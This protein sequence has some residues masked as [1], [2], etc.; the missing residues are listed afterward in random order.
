MI[1]K[2]FLEGIRITKELIHDIVFM[3]ENRTKPTYF[4]RTSNCKMD[5]TNIIHFQLNF[6]KKTLQLELDAFFKNIKG[7]EK[8][9]TKQGYSEARQKISPAAFIKMAD[10]IISWYY[11]DDSFKKFKGY[12]LCAIDAS[13]LEL[14]NSK[15]L[16]EAYGYGEGKTVKLARAKASAIYDIENDMALTSK[17]ARYTTGER[18]IAIELIEKLKQL[19]LKNDLILFD[20]GYP[21]KAFISYLEDSG[22]KY[23]IR[24]S[25]EKIKQ[26]REAVEP[27]QIIE[28]R[29]GKKTVKTRVVRFMLDSDVEEVLLTNLFDPSL[30]TQGF[31]ELYFK[32]WGIEVKYDEIKN[33]LQ[34]ENFT[35]DTVIAVEQDF[36]ASIY[37]S[38]MAALAKNEANERV[39]LRNQGKNLKYDYRVNV[40]ILIGKLK[41]SMVLMLLEDNPDKR[42]E[43]FQR[44][45]DE[46]SKNV[47]PT[48]PGRAFNRRKSLNANKH[49]ANQKRSL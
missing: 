35:G 41:D 26:V 36:Y 16:R 8:T 48:R 19:G 45:M 46:I 3:C 39:A 33:K 10:A 7:V 40:N 27:D 20:R 31:K 5:F 29:D 38:N 22:V 24:V 11:D 18:D 44:V 25:S 23:V 14:N 13:I 49:S 28:L 21:S 17:I 32:R 12:R 2:N 43:M 30:D 42:T 9:I 15:R 34:I 37:L 4:T 47:V 6:I 1:R